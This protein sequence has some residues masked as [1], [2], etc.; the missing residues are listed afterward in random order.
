MQTHRFGN[1]G[2]VVKRSGSTNKNAK[3]RIDKARHAFHIL[4]QIW[5]S[6]ILTLHNKIRIFNTCEVC[7][8]VWLGD[9][10]KTNTK[11][12]QTFIKRCLRNVFNISGPKLSSTMSYGAR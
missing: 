4:R 5:R 11:S 1:L 12:L 6:I 3:C 10:T 7:L 2:S 9:L 8:A